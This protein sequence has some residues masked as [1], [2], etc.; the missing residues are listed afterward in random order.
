MNPLIF[1][2][3]PEYFFRPSQ[4]FRRLRRWLRPPRE[5]ETVRLPWGAEIKVHTRETIGASI[6]S[7][8]IFDLPVC[9]AIARLLDPGE[10]ATDVGANIGQM[11]TLMRHRAGATGRVISFDPNPEIFTELSANLRD[12]SPHLAPIRLEQMALSAAPGE[13]SLDPGPEW[14][15]NRGMSRLVAD[16][17]ASA[18]SWRVKLTTLDALFPAPEPI[19][20][21]KMD[22][23]GHEA[24]VLAGAT[25]LLAERRIR[26]IIFEDFIT[27]PSPVANTLLAA[28]YTIFRLHAAWSRPQLLPPI[29]PA[30]GSASDFLATLDPARTTARFASRGWQALRSRA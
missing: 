3:R 22:V 12:T 27:Y 10:T 21:M 9:E 2:R 19:H 1:F 6:Y 17:N 15:S 5:I 14:K 8:G 18:Q 29:T 20:V 11:S 26:D 16:A 13:A 25:S 7:Y 28:G 30:H 4:A 24:S 23:E